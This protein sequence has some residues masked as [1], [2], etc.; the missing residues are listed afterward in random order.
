MGDGEPEL[1]TEAHVVSAFDCG[2]AALNDWLKRRG[3]A[4]QQSGSSRTWVIA[5]DQSRVV[6]YYAS[7]TASVLRA[8]APK[9]FGRNQPD[10]LPAI[11]LGR[12]AVDIQH[13]GRGLAAALLRHFLL[14]AIEVGERVGVRLVLTHAK[15]EEARRFY[16]HYG[17]VESPIDA[18]TMMLVLPEVGG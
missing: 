6:A 18:L 15:D 3:L 9:S 11:L 16:E 17:F 5:D 13:Q 12:L 10:E 7:S 1:L 2:R 14:K 8:T 4:N